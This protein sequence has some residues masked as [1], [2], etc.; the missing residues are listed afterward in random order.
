MRASGS[1]DAIKL[2]P[3]LELN[4]DIAVEYIQV[5]AG[6]MLSLPCRCVWV[7]VFAVGTYWCVHISIQ[8][9]I[10]HKHLAGV[11]LP[12]TALT[13]CFLPFSRDFASLLAMCRLGCQM[14]CSV[15]IVVMV[16]MLSIAGRRVSG[17]DAYEGAHAEASGLEGVGPTAQGPIELW[18]D[19]FV[20]GLTVGN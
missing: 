15:V 13:S 11:T 5:R 12:H 3:P 2:V 7:C 20:F 14:R 16:V 10:T 9:H 8:V 4:L 18:F 19:G 6:G 17:S 1:D